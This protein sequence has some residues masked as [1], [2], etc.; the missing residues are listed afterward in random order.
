MLGRE[1]IASLRNNTE[2]YI[3]AREDV[4]KERP[5]TRKWGAG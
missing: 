1:L 4:G 5:C 2:L 3:L